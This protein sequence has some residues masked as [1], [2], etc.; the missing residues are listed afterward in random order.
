MNQTVMEQS[1][2]GG[3]AALKGF[4]YQNYAAAYFVLSM[5]QDKSLI[6]VRF[7]VVDDIDLLYENKI[8]YVQVKT[9]D[10]DSKWDVREFAEATTKK[11]PPTGRQRVEQVVSQED[12]ILHKSMKCDK[13][14]LEGFFRILTP[15]DITDSLR[16]LKTPL[17][18]RHEKSQERPCILKRL[19][20]AVNRNRKNKPSFT[21][22]NGNDVAYWLDHAEWTIIPNKEHLQLLCAKM[23][24]ES[25]QKKGVFL[26][27]NNDPERILCSLLTNVTDKGAASRVI[28]SIKDKSY[29]R[30]DFIK[31]FNE[32]IEYYATQGNK[33]IKVYTANTNKLQAILSSFIKQ[34][35]LYQF[36]GNKSCTGLHGTYHQRKYNYDAITKNL[37]KWLPEVLLMP[38][39]IA[40]HAPEN[41]TNKITSFAERYNKNISFTNRLISQVLLHSTIRTGYRSQPIAAELYIN[42]RDNT[43]FDNIHILLQDHTNDKLI[44]GFSELLNSDFHD[45]LNKIISKFQ[46]LLESESFTDCKEKILAI[47]D[48]NYLLE[49]DIDEVLE[50]NKSLDDYIDR[51]IFSFFIGYESTLLSC[52]IR[53]MVDDYLEKLKDDV[54]YKFKS[55][56]T[57]LISE[58]D[59]YED[60]HIEVYLYPIPSLTS[61]ISSFKEQGYKHGIRTEPS[62]ISK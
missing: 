10:G 23:I 2:S 25:A 56:I 39:E 62:A 13:D 43:C 5:L 1:D 36:S 31:W 22:P 58:N 59:F 55:L 18:D 57:Q 28:H 14:I 27:A 20:N 29:H 45:S 47:K 48:D 17:A 21:S 51:F 15:R 8:E 30:S 34:D 49:H 3:V 35:K 12:S 41:I 32:E 37:Y 40:D 60:L 52:D 54:I 61:L 9:T 53:N 19:D 33:H 7:E 46:R 50:P 16:Y 4:T 6:S 42:D 44:M 38:E 11:V 24:L 26:I